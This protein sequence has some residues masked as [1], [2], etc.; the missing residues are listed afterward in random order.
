MPAHYNVDGVT[1]RL[2]APH[3]FVDASIACP[4]FLEAY[5][6]E[7]EILAVYMD[8]DPASP[9]R[10]DGDVLPDPFVE[11][12][13]PE[14]TSVM[15]QV[16]A[17]FFEACKFGVEE[18]IRGFSLPVRDAERGALP[19]LG[20]F[21]DG[22]GWFSC[23]TLRYRSDCLLGGMEIR[24]ADKPSSIVTG[25][26]TSGGGDSARPVMTPCLT[27]NI[28]FLVRRLPVIVN[29]HRSL[30]AESPW[31]DFDELAAVTEDYRRLLLP[32]NGIAL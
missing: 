24:E 13:I 23:C 26:A 5:Q 9:F 22:P 14:K 20:T 31:A 8:A 16:D 2:M 3:G 12:L 21:A 4:S 10:C 15:R 7:Q 25:G 18:S 29:L 19:P 30:D 11:V 17:A 1:I 28:V 27:G 6:R 32:L